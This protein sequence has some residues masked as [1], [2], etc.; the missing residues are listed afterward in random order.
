MDLAEQYVDRIVYV[1][2]QFNSRGLLDGEAKRRVAKLIR[3]YAEGKPIWRSAAEIM[4]EARK[5][6]VVEY[7]AIAPFLEKGPAPRILKLVISWGDWLE[8]KQLARVGEEDEHGRPDVI[9]IE[10]EGMVGR[11][12]A[13]RVYDEQHEILFWLLDREE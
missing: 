7:A 11:V 10:V 1:A 6:R 12:I 2:T 13:Y 5:T 3:D 9:G 4:I 8:A